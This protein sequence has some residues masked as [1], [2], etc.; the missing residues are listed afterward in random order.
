MLDTALTRADEDAQK[1]FT[2]ALPQCATSPVV[3]HPDEG[4]SLAPGADLA[5]WRPP[6]LP[7]Y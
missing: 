7:R 2:N 3:G 6:K 5:D 4:D 1:R